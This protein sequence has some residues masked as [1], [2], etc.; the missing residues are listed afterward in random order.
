MPDSLSLP[1]VGRIILIGSFPPRRCGIA[2]FTSDLRSALMAAK[3]GLEC[4]TLAM[5]DHGASYVYPPE[6][7]YEYPAKRAG[8]LCRGSRT[9]QYHQRRCDL[10]AA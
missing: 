4:S 3:P 2:T 1:S 8:R 6:V 5:T 9:Y 7:A 10:P